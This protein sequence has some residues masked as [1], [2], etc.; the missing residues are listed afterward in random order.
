MI[1]LAEN[2]LITWEKLPDDFPIADDPVDNIAQPYLAEGLTDSLEIAN[3]LPENSL[4]A[5][6]YP[7]CATLGGKVVLKA[8]DWMY[9][10][11]IKVS[12]TE[13]NRSYTPQLQGEIPTI[14]M[15]FLSDT[16]G[17]EYSS[18]PTYPPGK[19]FY[20]EQVLKVPHYF[21][22][23]PKEG[24]LEAYQLDESGRYKLRQPDANNRYALEP[25]QLFVGVWQ[26]TRRN[27]TG[28]WLRWW[29]HS[30]NLL[31][32][33]S[34][35]IEQERQRTEQERQRAERAEKAQRESI[36]R[37]LDM[38]LSVEQVA[39]ALGIPVEEVDNR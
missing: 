2:P 7:I 29:D 19:W 38:G 37:L 10:S 24:R 22:F 31:P 17:Q 15:E 8:P 1:V 27:R 26:G 35:Q 11:N 6:N 12:L 25:W 23:E 14:V 36:P 20:Y 28:Y 4:V 32:W 18:K 13:I 5:S 21:I 33:G 3:L 39:N 30:G 9:V 16:E 34:E